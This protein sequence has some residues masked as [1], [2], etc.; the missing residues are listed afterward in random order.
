M[1]KIFISYSTK[2][3]AQAEKLYKDLNEAGAAV[4]QFGQSATIGHPVWKEILTWIKG[5]DVFIVLVS[6]SSNNSP[7]VQ[8]EIEQAHYCYIN[9]NK[10]PLLVSAI[11]ERG[12]PVPDIIERF[13][14]VNFSTYT[15]GLRLLLNQLGIKKPATPLRTKQQPKYLDRLLDL[16][17][18][19]TQTKDR[20]PVSLEVK[21]WNDSARTILSNYDKLK[22]SKFNKLPKAK[23]ASYLDAVLTDHSRESYKSPTTWKSKDLYQL[24]DTFLGYKSME[25]E[26]PQSS[27]GEYAELANLLLNYD[28]S[29]INKALEA[30]NL[31]VI[32]PLPKVGDLI[33]YWT[34]IQDATG[35]RLEV[36]H[37]PEFKGYSSLVYSGTESMFVMKEDSIFFH[38]GSYRVKAIGGMFRPDSPWSNI[39]TISIIRNIR[40]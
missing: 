10:R 2:D 8:E 20:D 14:K 38:G 9:Q 21:K 40:A 24:T 28:Q 19:W 5:A 22:P 15:V 34:L 23:E 16:D 31:G 36:S 29:K 6:K 32:D 1:K 12:V 37:D 17:Q 13:N 26:Q 35:Y 25:K 7:P 27:G 33:F 11:L 4:F 39:V 30:P 18:I 3:K